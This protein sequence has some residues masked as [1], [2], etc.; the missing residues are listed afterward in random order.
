MC[1]NS[2]QTSNT[3]ASKQI[4]DHDSL[5]NEEINTQSMS[6]PQARESFTLLFVYLAVA[7]SLKTSF[8]KYLNKIK[9]SI[10]RQV[11]S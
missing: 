8:D 9:T 11:C 7:P 6:L 5:R 3:T 1:L 2:W 10:F 4:F